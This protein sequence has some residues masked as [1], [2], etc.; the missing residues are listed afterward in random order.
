[1]ATILLVLLIAEIHLRIFYVREFHP[2]PEI[3][4][5]YMPDTELIYFSRPSRPEKNIW[6]FIINSI[7]LRNEEILPKSKGTFRVIVLGDS[8]VQGH[9][10]E[11]EETYPKVLERL[12]KS[13]ERVNIEAINAGVPG[14][15]PDQE[16]KLFTERLVKLK[17]DLLLVVLGYSDIIWDN[18]Q[19]SLFT[20]KNDKLIPL[21][22]R[23]HWLYIQGVLF[24]SAPDWLKQSYL[25]DYIL[26]SLKGR[27]LFGL[28][29]KLKEEGLWEWSSDKV[30]KEMVNLDRLGREKGFK[31]IVV[32]HP[33]S[34]R[35]NVDERFSGDNYVPVLEKIKRELVKN[36]IDLI[37]TNEVLL[38]VSSA[39]SQKPFPM[40]RGVLGEK[41]FDYQKLFMMNEDA[42]ERHLT[43][44]G[45]EVFA[46][47]TFQEIQKYIPKDVRQ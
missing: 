44:L 23:K 45:N 15:G 46:E 18:I 12:L 30:V 6:G 14:Y 2:D 1:M 24:Q 4:R 10:M 29:P 36:R 13:N 22:A 37:D 3:T 34:S 28:N 19:R 11:L 8:F 7:G 25:F 9:M 31:L 33:I 47:L 35:L 17:P 32:I 38:S 27:D 5:A 21:D 42:G 26:T 20:I 43:V 41:T 16:Y 39:Y 40:S